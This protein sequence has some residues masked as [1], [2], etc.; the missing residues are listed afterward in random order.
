MFDDD[1]TS[2]CEYHVSSF[3]DPDEGAMVVVSAMLPWSDTTGPLATFVMPP[4]QALELAAEVTK[5]AVLAAG[6]W[7]K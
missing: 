6:R 2:E 1:S 3:I 4:K 7:W 5:A